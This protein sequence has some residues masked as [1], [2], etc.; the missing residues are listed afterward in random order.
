[1]AKLKKEV[2][3]TVR[4]PCAW[5]KMFSNVLQEIGLVR[6]KVDPSLFFL[7]SDEGKMKACLITYVDDAGIVGKKETVDWIKA[8]ISKRFG[9]TDL[10]KL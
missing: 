8:E 4:A 7:K 1:M 5:M 2:Y 9:I 10:G 6:S 3:G